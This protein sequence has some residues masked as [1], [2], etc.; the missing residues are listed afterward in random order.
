MFVVSGSTHQDSPDSVHADMKHTEGK[1]QGIQ[2]MDK[3]CEEKGL[4]VN[5]IAG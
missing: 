4:S 2:S 5:G 3:T 1:F